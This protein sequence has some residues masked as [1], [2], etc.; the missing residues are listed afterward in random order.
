MIS[1]SVDICGSNKNEHFDVMRNADGT[2]DVSVFR[3]RDHTLSN[4]LYYRR[5]FPEETKE[6]RLYGLQG[7]DSFQINGDVRKS[8]LVRLVPGSGSNQIVDSSEV[9]SVARKTRVYAMDDS[10]EIVGS[11]EIR[12]VH[13]P[14]PEAY[15]YDR[16]RFAYDTY[17][18]LIYLYASSGNGIS[19]GGGV[20]F[21]RQSYDKPGYSSKHG[22]MGQASTFGNFKLEYTGQLRHVVGTWD[23]AYGTSIDKHYRFNYFFGTGNGTVIDRDLIG[24]NYYTLQFSSLEIYGGLS[25]S[26]WE[27]SKVEGIFTLL[28]SG[29]ENEENNI[30]EPGA[31]P[32]VAGNDRL[33]IAKVHVA[34]DIDFRDRVNLPQRG[35]RFSCLGLLGRALN[36]DDVT[37]SNVKATL[38]YFVTMK[39]LTLGLKVGGAAHQGFT[40]FFDLYYLGQNK[41]LRGFRQNRFTGKK[42]AFAN[43]DLRIHIL[44]SPKSLIPF[45]IG[46]VLFADAGRIFESAE[47][48]N[49]PGWHVGYGAGFYFVPLRERFAI[50]ISAG[51]SDEESGLIR[52]GLGKSF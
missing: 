27:R 47:T 31:F 8:I 7:D 29:K 48:A 49:D 11:S 35:M 32:D 41:H 45:K 25:R 23:L 42:L 28:G 16:T 36:N 1:K 6:V 21:T 4:P 33:R 34:C 18:P 9:R 15:R 39:P 52:F 51:F 20:M 22:V 37:Y 3:G 13:I 46:I 5:F 40:P 43:T 26:F 44:D 30:F 2:V 24:T 12:S 38:E 50:Q 14:Y 10:A 19:V 17:F